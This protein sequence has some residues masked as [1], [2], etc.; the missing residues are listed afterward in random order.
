MYSG[1]FAA[2][3][4][5]D[6][7][8]EAFEQARRSVPDLV[9]VCVGATDRDQVALA[10]Q[11]PMDLEANLRIVPR[12]PREKIPA[13]IELAD[14]LVLPRIGGGNIPL[15]LYDYM[16]SGKPIVATRQ[17]GSRSLLDDT[18]AFICEPDAGSLAN[19]MIKVCR[20][21]RR[22]AVMAE[23]SA[24]FARLNFGWNPFVEFV[25]D[26]YNRAIRVDRQQGGNLA[27]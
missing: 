6:L 14:F 4:G 5:V 22:A 2:Y 27:A 8:L 12:Q 11:W 16:A 13:F 9:L 3:Q 23:E 7:L 24:R 20:S 17:A 18:R 15:K 1:S 10:R 19:A 26:T 25:G 21:P